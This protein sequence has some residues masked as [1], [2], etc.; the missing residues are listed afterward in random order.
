MTVAADGRL[1]LLGRV[2]ARLRAAL[3]CREQDDAAG[4]TDGERGADV[5]A[6][7]QL[8]D[9]ERVGAVRVD[10]FA[11]P[12]CGCRPDGARRDAAAGSR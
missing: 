8:L 5:D 10:Q 6:E 2:G 3:P 4:L 11:D 1:D 9:R 7:E 12:P